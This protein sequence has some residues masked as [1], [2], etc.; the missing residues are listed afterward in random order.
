MRLP[1]MG[2]I[3][4]STQAEGSSEPRE[5]LRSGYNLPALQS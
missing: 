3:A 1:R 4:Y 5:V 2:M